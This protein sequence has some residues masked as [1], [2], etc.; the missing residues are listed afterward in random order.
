M[1]FRKNNR[2]GYIY[3]ETNIGHPAVLCACT[4]TVPD[5][6]VSR[7]SALGGFL[8]SPQ[9]KYLNKRIFYD[10]ISAVFCIE[11]AAA[12][13]GS[14]RTGA[15][16]RRKR[17]RSLRAILK[18]GRVLCRKQNSMKTIFCFSLAGNRRSWRCT[19][20]CFHRWKQHFRKGLSKCRKA[21]SAFTGGIC[22]LWCP[23]PGENGTAVSL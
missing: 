12:R 9:M 18:R 2:A 5:D 7:R 8:G 13:Q 23:C 17:M 6:G 21:R 22:L 4:G 10:I 15:R 14:A 11:Q 20:R 16:R 1:L 3:E 19:R